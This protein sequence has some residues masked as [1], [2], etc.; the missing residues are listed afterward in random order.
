MLAQ[1]TNGAANSYDG[2]LIERCRRRTMSSKD[3]TGGSVTGLP[4]AASSS[5][6]TLRRVRNSATCSGLSAST[7]EEGCQVGC[8]GAAAS[9]ERLLAPLSL[10]ANA[11]HLAHICA[12]HACRA[13]RTQLRQ[14]SDRAHQR[15]SNQPRKSTACRRETR[16]PAPRCWSCPRENL[17]SSCSQSLRCDRRSPAFPAKPP[18]REAPLVLRSHLVASEEERIPFD[19]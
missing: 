17:I 5:T 15:R 7:L 1:V 18:V 9:G 4:D 12:V 2:K 8:A 3:S 19:N 14:P 16:H 13:G 11:V 6:T 10:P